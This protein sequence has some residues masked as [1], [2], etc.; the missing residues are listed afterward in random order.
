MKK[1]LIFSFLLAATSIS[2]SALENSAVESTMNITATI[3]KPLTVQVDGALDFGNI[4]AS[5]TSHAY[6]SFTVKGEENA[7][8]KISFDNLSSDGSSFTVPIYSNN[9][10]F[11]NITFNC[12]A[13]NNPGNL[14]NHTNNTIILT[15]GGENTL[16]IAATAQPRL[17]QTP[18]RYTG[19]I[20]MRATYE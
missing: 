2:Y 18:G 7:K 17:N 3:I 14:L 9:K 6:S 5:S 16:S 20:T 13:K 8:V 4:L 19:Q 11:F 10:D 12:T 1:I 15:D